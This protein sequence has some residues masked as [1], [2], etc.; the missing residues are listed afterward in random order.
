LAATSRRHHE[1]VP[2]ERADGLAGVL[3][4]RQPEPCLDVELLRVGQPH[5][6]VVVDELVI[7]QRLARGVQALEDLLRVGGGAEG[8]RDVLELLQSRP[9]L[10]CLVGVYLAAEERVVVVEP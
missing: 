5:Q 7:T 6:H 3:L 10:R 1:I 8:D 2:P 9:D 4:D